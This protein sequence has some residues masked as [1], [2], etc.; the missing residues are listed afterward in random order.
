MTREQKYHFCLRL[1]DALEHVTENDFEKD[2]F[3][4]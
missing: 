2:I 4:I 3:I 1:V